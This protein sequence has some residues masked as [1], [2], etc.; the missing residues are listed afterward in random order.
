MHSRRCI[1]YIS[2]IIQRN[3]Q[4]RFAVPAAFVIFEADAGAGEVVLLRGYAVI[5]IDHAVVE[6]EE[7]PPSLLVLADGEAP[8]EGGAPAFV[9]GEGAFLVT[10]DRRHAADGELLRRWQFL[11]SGVLPVEAIEEVL[12]VVQLLAPHEVGVVVGAIIFLFID[13]IVIL[14]SCHGSQGEPHA[15]LVVASNRHARLHRAGHIV[16]QRHAGVLRV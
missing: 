15:V 16:G 13:A 4:D 5:V 1:S 2:R 3:P 6:E 14:V 12:A 10:S 9:A 7:A 11:E 8:L